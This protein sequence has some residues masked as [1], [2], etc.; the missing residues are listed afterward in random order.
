[1]GNETNKMIGLM[2]SGGVD[3]AVLLDELLRRN[4]RVQPIYVAM[5]C[6]WD[7]SERLAITRF[8]DALNDTLIEPLMEF[9]SP[10][11]D[12][13]GEHWSVT[14]RAVPDESTPDEAVFMWGRN[15]MLLLKPLLWCQQLG[16]QEL[17]LGTLAANPFADATEEYL[18]RFA[19]SVASG[20]ETPVRIVQPF[21]RCSKHEVLGRASHLPLE[22]T[23]SCLAPQRGLHCGR[24]NKCAERSGVLSQLPYGD[25]TRYARVTAAIG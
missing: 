19:C 7:Q 6:A 9:D 11:A 20:N 15:P 8:I 4:H 2:L 25:P 12:L 23:F 18:N 10:V 21:N 16:V 17:A 13:Y 5:G 1:M 14:G 22:L 24:C 3:S